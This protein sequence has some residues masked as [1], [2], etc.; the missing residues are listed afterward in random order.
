MENKKIKRDKK[1]VWIGSHVTTL[2]GVSNAPLNAS[3]IEAKAFG[4]F[5]KNQRRWEAKPYTMEEIESFK[6]NLKSKGYIPEQ[7]LPH[8]GY[9]INLGNSDEEKLEKSIIAFIDEINRADSLGLVYLN[10]HPGSHLNELSEDECLKLISNSINR[11]IRETKNVKIVLEN[12]AGQGTNLGYKFE[13]LGK[14]IQGIE[15]KNRIGV[16]IDTCHTLA[17]G[18]ELKDEIGYENTMEEF[19]KH[20]GFKYLCGV[21]LNDSKFDTGSK[22]DRHDSIGKGV[23]GLDFFK[24]FMNDTRFDNIPI[25]L[26]TIDDTIWDKEIKYLYSLID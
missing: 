20:I 25:I 13:Q 26:E 24:R 11:A 19:E 14:I 21:H 12:T 22:K 1:K 23:L 10:T 2:G 8:D 18:Y 3:K 4:M 9:M 16:C 15:E 6:E 5:L 7:V 17:S